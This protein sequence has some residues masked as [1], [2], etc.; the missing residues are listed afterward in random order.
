MNVS[1]ASRPECGTT[2]QDHAP[3]T[4][5]E[6]IPLTYSTRDLTLVRDTS[7][8]YGPGG[9]CPDDPI[10]WYDIIQNNDGRKIGDFG[11]FYDYPSSVIK[12]DTICIYDGSDRGKGYGIQVYCA[13]PHMLMPDGKL[14]SE[15]G[16]SYIT[17]RHS[18]DAERVWGELE[19]R[20]LATNMG[21]RAYM[22][23]QDPDV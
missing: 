19:R 20:G 12:M 11:V 13:L 17:E 21:G 18:D 1:V 14:P 22:W 5:A 8:E 23:G 16:F 7:D 10:L 9:Y 2:R 15:A 3:K 4:L 6:S